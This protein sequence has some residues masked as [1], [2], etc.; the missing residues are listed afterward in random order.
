MSAHELVLLSPYRFPGQYSLVL[1]PEDMAAWLNGFSVLWHPGLLWGA[2]GPPRVEQSYDHENPQPG[3]VYALPEAPPLYLPDDW[4]ERV[5]RAGAFSFKVSVDRKETLENLR[6]ALADAPSAPGWKEAVD[7]PEDR[8]LPFFAIGWGH[9]LVGTLSEAM[10]HENL[11]ETEPF[12]DHVQGAIAALAGFDYQPAAPQQTG[13]DGSTQYDSSTPSDEQEFSEPTGE[14]PRIYGPSDFEEFTP[15]DPSFERTEALAQDTPHPDE[16]AGQTANVEPWYAALQKAAEKLLSAREVLYPVQIHLLDLYLVDEKAWNHEWPASIAAGVPCNLLISG[17]NL[18]RLQDA[19][20][21]RFAELRD[22]VQAD[23]VDICGGG[24]LEREDPLLPLESQLWN[25]RRGKETIKRLLGVDVQVFARKRFGYHP[26][27]PLLLTTS[28]F[29]KALFLTFDENAAL[30]KY[31]SSVIG[32][33]S[34]DGKQVDAFV[35]A[36]HD[37]SDSQTFF[38]LGHTW[39][40]TTREDHNATILFQHQG[41]ATC[42]WY[43]DLIELA[44]LAPVLGTWTT[45]SRYL[46]DVYAGEHPGSLSA[47][48]FHSDFLSERVTAHHAH[49][50]SEFAEHFRIRRRIDACST[51]AA[52]HHSLGGADHLPHVM[53]RLNDI[54]DAFETH[55]SRPQK[56]ADAPTAHAGDW[57]TQLQEL[58]KSIPAGLAERLQARAQPNQPGTMILNPCAFIRRVALELE[59][60][61]R[62]LAIQG[63]VKACQLDADKLRVVVEV[64]ALGYAWIPKEGPVGTKAMASKIRMADPQTMTIRNEFYEVEV[65]TGTGGLKAIKD[66]RTRL[67]R[68]GQRL[69]FNPGSRMI[70]KEV[71]VTHSGP[72]FAEIV[73]TGELVGEQDQ[74]LARFTQRFRLWMGRPMLEMRVTLEPE[75]PA[76]GYAWHAYFGSRFAW[77]DERG[78]LLR[79]ASGTGYVSTHPRPQTPDYIEIRHARQGTVILPGGLPFHQRQEGRMLDVILVPEGEEETTFDLGIAFDR[80]QPTQTAL[81]VVSPVAVVPTQKGPP[82]IGDSGW[83]FHLDAPNLVMTRMTLGAAEVKPTWDTGADS[84]GSTYG[85]MRSDDDAGGEPA[86]SE[87]ASN[88]NESKPAHVPTAI[89]TARLFECSGHSGMAELRCVK[90]PTRACVLNGRGDFLLEAGISADAVLL[91]VTPN[92]FV[93]VQIEF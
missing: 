5:K 66:H 14:E 65:D 89:V 10:E 3:F 92:D 79:A 13:S 70:A 38:N 50:V 28:G 54:E 52:L 34:P 36:G 88:P 12:W 55:G 57:L 17:A 9:L 2:K 15:A 63:P 41:Q 37:T 84:A 29:T 64:P 4:D 77:R 24:Y 61:A 23:R 45:F 30:P 81:G 76:A 74:V 26:L 6:A 71:R 8:I 32:W 86:N 35:R 56:Q 27:T 40:K 87:N 33:P 68:L 51:Y 7:L 93:Q 67:N 60:G 20:P 78:V 69:V 85:E 46:A 90:N 47:D 1:G 11:L 82:H 62:P 42:P 48:E 53:K 58:E 49:P 91:E 72:A 44:K 21:E 59:P 22:A 39:F 43:A 16:D 80:D 73:A 31:T 18:E 75:Q 19:K 25:L 83:L